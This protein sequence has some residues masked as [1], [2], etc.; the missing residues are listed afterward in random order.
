MANETHNPLVTLTTLF[1]TILSVCFTVPRPYYTCKLRIATIIK[2]VSFF[3]PYYVIRVTAS[4]TNKHEAS[5]KSANTKT[6]PF[7]P[8]SKLSVGL[9]NFASNCTFLRYLLRHFLSWPRPSHFRGVMIAFRLKNLWLVYTLA[10]GEFIIFSTRR[11][12]NQS[13]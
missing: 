3:P 7:K 1:K 6:S 11:R 8:T 9:I 12:L 10:S 13:Y 4:I 2:Y 5:T